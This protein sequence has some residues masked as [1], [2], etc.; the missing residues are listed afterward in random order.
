MVTILYFAMVLAVLAILSLIFVQVEKEVGFRF[1]FTPLKIKIYA[2]TGTNRDNLA[3]QPGA[4]MAAGAEPPIPGNGRPAQALTTV[5]NQNFVE[6][7]IQLDGRIFQDCSFENCTLVYAGHTPA[8]FVQCRFA[9][10]KWEVTAAA[11]NVMQ[12]LESLYRDGGESGKQWVEQALA[13]ITS[14]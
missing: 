6:Q 7:T 14:N 5:A 3:T 13:G 2:K 11:E 12:F 9:E 4:P 1:S 8:S 10:T